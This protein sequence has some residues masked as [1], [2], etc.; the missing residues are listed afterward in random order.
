MGRDHGAKGGGGLAPSPCHFP[1]SPQIQMQLPLVVGGG[2]AGERHI[3]ILYQS[4]YYLSVR[5]SHTGV[6]VQAWFKLGNAVK[7]PAPWSHMIPSQIPLP[8]TTADLIMHNVYFGFKIPGV[9]VY[10]SQMPPA[11]FTKTRTSSLSPPRILLN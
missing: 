2:L 10:S 6:C 5:N 1:K 11:S 7:A 8:I 9:R 3:P 4:F